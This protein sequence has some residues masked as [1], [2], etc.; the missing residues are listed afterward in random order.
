MSFIPGTPALHEVAAP[1]GW[2]ALLLQQDLPVDSEAQR[3][4]YTEAVAAVLQRLPVLQL[5]PAEEVLLLFE[6]LRPAV[7]IPVFQNEA[8]QW[9]PEFG[10]GVWL[11]S[12]APTTWTTD[13]FLDAD[14]TTLRPVIE[15]VVRV[16]Q[17]PQAQR[18]AWDRLL[19]SGALLRTLAADPTFLAGATA[20]LKPTIADRSLTSF[21]FY[22]PLLRAGELQRVG[23]V[24][25]EPLEAYL[26]GVYAYLRESVEDGGLLVLFRRSPELFWNAF[27]RTPLDMDVVRITQSKP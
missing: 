25:D 13:E 14:P 5:I 4:R 15:R 17:N 2:T 8:R 3:S 16:A 12:E 26:P 20:V 27:L 19:G 1:A 10:M 9:M 23:P 6:R 21:P 7:E 11:H 24:Y 18:G 22:L